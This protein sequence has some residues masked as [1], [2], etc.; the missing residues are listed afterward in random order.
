MWTGR[1]CRSLRSSAVSSSSADS[2]ATREPSSAEKATTTCAT[3][4]MAGDF[5]ISKMPVVTSAFEL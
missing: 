2:P 3:G 5:S 1:D 4:T